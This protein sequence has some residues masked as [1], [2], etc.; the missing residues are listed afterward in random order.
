MSFQGFL[1]AVGA[2]I[3]AAV[4]LSAW[5][6]GA[7]NQVGRRRLLCSDGTYLY[8]IRETTSGARLCRWGNDPSGLFY[9]WGELVKKL[10]GADSDWAKANLEEQKARAEVQA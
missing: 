8:L 1:I 10:D 3:V 4:M 9:P 7:F 2:L 5:A 6:S